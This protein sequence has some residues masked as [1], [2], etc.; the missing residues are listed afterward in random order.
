MRWRP[1]ENQ[2]LNG[3]VGTTGASTP[4]RNVLAPLFILCQSFNSS[5][6]FSALSAAC[7]KTS[8]ATLLVRK[9]IHLPH[10]GH[11]LQLDNVATLRAALISSITSLDSTG[12]PPLNSLVDGAR[13]GCATLPRFPVTNRDKRG[14]VFQDARQPILF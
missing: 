4:P 7:F 11:S 2:P 9:Q 12:F 1:Y 5:R 3:T 8:I 13:Q 6:G 10:S 14:Q